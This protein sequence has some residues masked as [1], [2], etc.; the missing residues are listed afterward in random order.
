MRRWWHWY[1]PRS[2]GEALV[3]G[4]IGAALGFVI[5]VSWR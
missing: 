1:G 4:L 5:T 3:Y 2:S